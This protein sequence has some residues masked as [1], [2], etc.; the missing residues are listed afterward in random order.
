[1]IRKKIILLTFFSTFLLNGC[2]VNLENKKTNHPHNS[3]KM[4]MENDDWLEYVINSYKKW[5]IPISTQLAIIKHESSFRYDARP[6]KEKGIFY[7][8]YQS[9]ALGFSQALN[10]TW[11]EYQNN[12]GNKNADRRSFKDS[13]DFIGWYLNNASKTANISKT[14]T[15]SFYLAYHE[16]IGGYKS[17]SY[18]KKKWLVKKASVVKNTAENYSKQLKACNL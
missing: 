14:D 18:L 4:L 1:M 10:G 9:S 12:T 17:K 7:D 11:K 8:T 15:Y 5:K 3:C 2:A 13:V 6:I 16:G